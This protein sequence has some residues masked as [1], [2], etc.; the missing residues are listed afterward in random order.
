MSE[1]LSE[2]IKKVKV[3][4]TKE[5]T[6]VKCDIC[7]KVIP[8]GKYP[9][10]EHKYYDVMTGHRDWGND[11]CESIEHRDICPDCLVGFVADYFKDNEYSSAY[12][13]IETEYASPGIREFNGGY[14][15]AEDTND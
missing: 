13:E 6:G 9:F 11:S 7:G 15:N 5:V 12:M 3:V 10:D 1:I 4:T 2:G 8:V 14:K